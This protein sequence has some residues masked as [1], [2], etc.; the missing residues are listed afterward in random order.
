MTNPDAP[1]TAAELA[2]VRAASDVIAAHPGAE[3][4]KN[5]AELGERLLVRR[6]SAEALN[7]ILNALP[8][9]LAEAEQA[10]ALKAACYED[11]M[12]DN[13]YLGGYRCRLC[14]YDVA[15]DIPESHEPR[16]VLYRGEAP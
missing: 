8:R 3:W 9:L 7:T 10:A 16:C 4:P 1:L 12:D 14:G 5:S 15:P 13:H 11:H 2:T 6:R